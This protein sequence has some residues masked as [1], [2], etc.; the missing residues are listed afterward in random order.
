VGLRR[1]RPTEEDYGQKATSL[2]VYGVARCYRLSVFRKGAA[3][4]Q[5]TVPGLPSFASSADGLKLP[6]LSPKQIRGRNP[7][8][9]LCRHLQEFLRGKSPPASAS[10]SCTRLSAQT[11][12]AASALSPAAS[13]SSAIMP[14][15][16]L[17][18][19]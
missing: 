10:S 12:H 5:R 6:L 9:T 8:L 1:G 18:A 19:G 11:L 7:G 4:L 17:G 2:L 16:S 14:S 3:T 15:P 13:T